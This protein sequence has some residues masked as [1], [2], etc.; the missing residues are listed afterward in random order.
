MMSPAQLSYSQ[1][2][3]LP[4]CLESIMRQVAAFLPLV[5]GRQF[6]S[7]EQARSLY[8][9]DALLADQDPSFSSARKENSETLTAAIFPNSF[10]NHTDVLCASS[11]SSDLPPIQAMNSL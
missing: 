5:S 3:Q 1:H 2:D 7:E 9:P 4:S 10:S 6:R 8:P 11:R